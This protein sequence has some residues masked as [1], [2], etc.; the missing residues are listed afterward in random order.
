MKIYT[1]PP[2]ESWIC[3]RLTHEWREH[4]KELDVANPADADIIWLLA[5]WVSN[6]IPQTH[7]SKKKVVASI[8]HITPEKFNDKE[9]N[10]FKVRDRFVDL[11]H[12][13][14]EATRDQIAHL[15]DKPIVVQ[16]FWVNQYLWHDLTSEDD[17]KSATKLSPSNYERRQRLKQEKLGMGRDTFVIGSFQRDTEGHDLKSPK[18]EKGPDV[19]CDYIGLA[20]DVL[21]KSNVECVVLLGGWRRQYIQQRLTKMGIRFAYNQR[22]DFEM[23][24]EMYNCLDLY[25]VSAR[26]EGGPQAIVEAAITQTPIISTDVGLAKHIL[27]PESIASSVSAEALLEANP[28]IKAAYDNVQE[29]CMPQGFTPFIEMFKTL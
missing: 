24:N 28:N 4:H 9:V 5:E 7:L 11:Y 6:R 26:Y 23:I 19:F 29:Y 21:K 15:T 2:N 14:C 20:R 17:E 8:H 22:P 10:D 1:L 12:V 16:P 27:A 13:P 3:D 25:V 18:L